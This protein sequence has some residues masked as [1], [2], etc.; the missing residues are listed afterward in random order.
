MRL[1]RVVSE[2]LLFRGHIVTHGV[3]E[4]SDPASG[5][6]FKRRIHHVDDPFVRLLGRAQQCDD[7]STEILVLS[8]KRLGI[9]WKDRRCI[10]GQVVISDRSFMV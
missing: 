1:P 3:P 9:N 5:I 7:F 2:G 8:Q 6:R 10:G 4:K